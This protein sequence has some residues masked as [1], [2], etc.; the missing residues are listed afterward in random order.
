MHLVVEDKFGNTSFISY[1]CILQRLAQPVF[2]P[3]FHIYIN[4]YYSTFRCHWVNGYSL[5]TSVQLTT[6]S[7][8][9]T[10][11]ELIYPLFHT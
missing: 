3:T 1:I 2:Q 9:P 4:L 8:T 5:H 7:T 6:Q 10:S 11:Y